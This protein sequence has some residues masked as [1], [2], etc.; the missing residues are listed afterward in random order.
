MK[1]RVKVAA[2]ATLALVAL[3]VATPARAETYKKLHAAVQRILSLAI[4]N[5]VNDATSGVTSTVDLSGGDLD[6]C[7]F[8]VYASSAV[9]SGS[10]SF[11]IQ[12]SP[13][14]GTSWVPTGTSISVSTTDASTVATAYSA[15]ANT[16]PGTKLRL[17]PTLT[18]STSFYAIKVWA[19]AN[20]N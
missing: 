8:A 12:V 17:V 13:D 18:G 1:N 14:G 2:M 10:A 16:G 6:K 15:N 11:A 5:D 9:G 3:A 20:T 19:I 4:L 7:S